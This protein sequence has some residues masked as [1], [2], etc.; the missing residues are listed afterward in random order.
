MDR[1]T[2][3][4]THYQHDPANPK[5]LSHNGVFSIHEDA[6]GTLWI[7]THGGGLNRMDPATHTFIH[8]ASHN[9]DLTTNTIY[10]IQEDEIGQLWLSTAAGLFRFDPANETV[11][12][13]DVEDGLPSLEFNA[14]AGFRSARDG[15][16][17]FG[18]IEGA[19]AFFPRWFEPN[20][21]A[22]Q[23]VL[24]GFKLFN[25]DV[26]AAEGS[27]L[28]QPIWETK[29]VRLQKPPAKPVPVPVRTV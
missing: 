19:F 10:S 17:F 25:R 27:P 7:G 6:S 15:E 21:T 24:T 2:G 22:P 20:P 13:F 5:S 16:M 14:W 8:Y 4:F 18:T 29:E 1:A 12:A 26:M 9:S 11:R 3:T 23:V 28:Q